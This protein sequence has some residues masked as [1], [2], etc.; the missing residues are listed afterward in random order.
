MNLTLL[1]LP[2]TIIDFAH[3]LNHLVSS[4]YHAP[5]RKIAYLDQMFDDY[6][7]PTVD[8][9]EFGTAFAKKYLLRN[10]WK[11][12]FCFSHQPPLASH[13]VIDIGCGSAAATFA[14]L[15]LL[16]CSG[17]KTYV[18]LQLVDQS[19]TQLKIAD[20]LLRKS[21]QFFQSVEYSYKMSQLNFIVNPTSLPTAPLK[22][23]VFAIPPQLDTGDLLISNLYA[24]S[25]RGQVYLVDT[26]K[27]SEIMKIESFLSSRNIMSRKIDISI[28]PKHLKYPE[29]FRK[30]NF[31]ARTT[32]R[33]LT[34]VPT[35]L[36]LLFKKGNE[37]PN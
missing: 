37:I 34:T 36:R 35:N 23:I 7:R 25:D 9:D 6:V 8:Y 29:V 22:F 31:G 10:Y 4:E 27:N 12:I 5:Q 18:D 2:R 13:Q 11:T 24:H 15:A 19:E 30:Y 33:I 17:K 16:E 1:D 14:Y 20:N 28:T 26:V 32:A 3:W 21:R